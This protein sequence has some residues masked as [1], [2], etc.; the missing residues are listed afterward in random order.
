M[1]KKRPPPVVEIEADET[2][3]PPIPFVFTELIRRGLVSQDE[4][5]ALCEH[6]DVS[7]AR[8]V[9]R[10]ATNPAGVQ[11]PLVYCKPHVLGRAAQVFGACLVKCEIP[12]ATRDDLPV[13]FAFQITSAIAQEFAETA[14]DASGAEVP[15]QKMLQDAAPGMA[16]FLMLMFQQM[17]ANQTMMENIAAK[18]G[19]PS[20]EMQEIRKAMFGLFHANVENWTKSAKKVEPS[21]AEVFREAING[22]KEVRG[23]END[24]RALYPAGGDNEIVKQI[25]GAIKDPGV[26]RKAGRVIVAGV[27]ALGG[28]VPG[29]ADENEIDEGEIE[30]SAEPPSPRGSASRMFSVREAG[31]GNGKGNGKGNGNGHGRTQQ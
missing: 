30:A 4:A 20:D 6:V 23:A 16:P 18:L 13:F 22:I 8:I 9:M 25:V 24:L 27:K 5:D 14:R 11:E 19:Q 15:L 12:P 31:A 1:A 7:S 28:T 26:R 3:A 10:G 17:K 29:E 21:A 2:D